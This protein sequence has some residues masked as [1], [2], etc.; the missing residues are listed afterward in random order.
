MSFIYIEHIQSPEIRFQ[1]LSYDEATGMGKLL[2]SLGVTID[3]LITPAELK[4]RNYHIKVSDVELLNADW[5][6]KAPL[7]PGNN[8]QR[9]AK[10]APMV[11]DDEEDE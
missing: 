1:V 3:R 4:K 5:P 10:L 8:E 6:A 2:S 9:K 7:N 11:E